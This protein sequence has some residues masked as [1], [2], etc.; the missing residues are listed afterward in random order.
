VTP[1]RHPEFTGVRVTP[2]VYTTGEEVDRFAEAME[3]V[4][5]R[6]LPATA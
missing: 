4:L 1:I 2:S 3:R 6:G 5:A